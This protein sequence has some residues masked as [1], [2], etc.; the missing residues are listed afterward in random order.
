MNIE[1]ATRTAQNA[2]NAAHN[3]AFVKG[4]A[5]TQGATNDL[6]V[7]WD[8]LVAA[9]CHISAGRTAK[10]TYSA[11]T[12]VAALHAF[13]VDCDQR[14][15]Q[16]AHSATTNGTSAAMLRAQRRTRA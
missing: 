4:K 3:A 2:Y 13:T 11:E 12:L 14:A 10:T 7:R 8:D 5:N 1:T 9:Y 16:L 6:S 15:A